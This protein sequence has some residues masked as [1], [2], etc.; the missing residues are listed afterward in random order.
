MGNINRILKPC[1]VQKHTRLYTLATSSAPVHT[2]PG[3]HPASSRIGTGSHSAP[4]TS[5]IQSGVG[6][7]LG[8][9]KRMLGVKK[10]KKINIKQA[11]S[12]H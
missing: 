9:R 12:S 10:L 6:V 1:Q 2:G 4:H 5:G 8:V 11:Q 7:P 3:A